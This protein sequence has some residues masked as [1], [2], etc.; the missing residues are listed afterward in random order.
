MFQSGWAAALANENRA[1]TVVPS[2]VARWGWPVLT[3]TF[4]T[5]SAALAIAL[6]SPSAG[7]G[8]P[9][10]AKPAAVAPNLVATPPQTKDPIVD[11]VDE[12]FSQ[13]SAEH[14]FVPL[15]ERV[16][17]LK[18]SPS[19]ALAMRNRMLRTKDLGEIVRPVVYNSNPRPQPVPLRAGSY[20]NQQIVERL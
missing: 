5:L 9:V 1:Q 20:K 12:N 17:R 14:V 7:D 8:E 3:G 11:A 13:E 4:A 6:F 15:I 19:S 16:F 2:Q 10:A 18:P